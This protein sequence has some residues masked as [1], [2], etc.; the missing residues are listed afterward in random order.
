M[1]GL[2]GIIYV[3]AIFH[4]HFMDLIP[5][6]RSLLIEK[7]RDGVLVLDLRNRIMDINPA[8]GSFIEGNISSYI[9]KNAFE[10]FR[11]WMEKKDLFLEKM[12]TRLQTKSSQGSVSL[13]GLTGNPFI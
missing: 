9:G 11:P 3:F 4:T 12:E 8:M 13:R 7:M 6:A 5:I 10:V 2:S 1:F